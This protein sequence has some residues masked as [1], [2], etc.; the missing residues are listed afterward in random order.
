MLSPMIGDAVMRDPEMNRELRENGFVVFTLLEP[1]AVEQLLA[2]WART[3]SDWTPR[4]DPTGLLATV[5]EPTV[6]AA[7][8]QA[9]RP[10]IE[11]ALRSWCSAEPFTSAYLVKQPHS[12]ALP[13]H[14][15]FRLLD[16]T[17]HFTFGCW[18]ALTDV[19][20]STGT[21]GVF[22][23]SHHRVDF[24]RNPVDP[25]HE[26]VAAHLHELGEPVLIEALAGTAVI[27]DHRLVHFSPP[28]RRDRI[29]LATNTGLASGGRHHEARQRIFRHMGTTPPDDLRPSGE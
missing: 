8:D 10:V 24:D 27:Y 14:L 3:C 17:E 29:R 6:A 12:S 15:D 26:W 25:G 19:D 20:E 5:R 4:Y 7:A 16:E 1:E 9:I 21:L 2:G 13:P 11:R 23:R 22:P 18:T 28:N